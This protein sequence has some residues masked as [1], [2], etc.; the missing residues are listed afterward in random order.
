M[1]RGEASLLEKINEGFE[2]A[3]KWLASSLMLA[4]GLL[5]SFEVFNRYILGKP[6]DY[7]DELILYLAICGAFLGAAIASRHGRHTKIDLLIRLIAEGRKKAFLEILNYCATIAACILLAYAGFR[8]TFFLKELQI[9]T[10]STLEIPLWIVNIA[11]PIGLILCG[12]FSLERLLLFFIR[13]K[14]DAKD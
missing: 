9:C 10:P 7:T 8:H 12:Y 14:K 2:T 3:I 11:F 13:L 1:N 4:A 5:V 6:K